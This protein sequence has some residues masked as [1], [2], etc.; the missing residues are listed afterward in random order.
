[1]KSKFNQIIFLSIGLMIL[2]G[3]V[4]Q[5]FAGEL[6]FKRHFPHDIMEEIFTHTDLEHLHKIH[7][8]KEFNL[9]LI[10]KAGRLI[11]KEI[12]KYLGEFILLPEVTEIELGRLTATTT[13][14]IAAFRAA[15]SKTSIGFYHAVMGQYPDI[16]QVRS[17]S[18]EQK[19]A[20]VTQWKANPDLPVTY[21]TSDE[22]VTFAQRLS[23][24]TG[25]NF[26]VMSRAENEYSIRGRALVD[27]SPAG[28]ITRTAYFFGDDPNQL[29]T[30]GWFQDNSDNKVCAVDENPE[31]YS[32]PFGLNQALGNILVRSPD[33]AAQGGSFSR[34]EDW[35]LARSGTSYFGTSRWRSADIGFRLGEYFNLNSQ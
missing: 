20:L 18:P 26:R 15:K 1:M 22:D 31:G 13:Q 17:L 16:S 2:A 28:S 14:P 35:S 8:S 29:P 12:E 27:E 19:T 9:K 21:S 33:G 7:N 24:I 25:R 34:G 10:Q 6:N 30:Y 5:S 32:H 11:R 23:Q 3:E 4:P